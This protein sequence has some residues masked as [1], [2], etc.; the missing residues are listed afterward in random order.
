[1]MSISSPVL[2]TPVSILPVATVPRPVIE[3][4]SSTGIKKSFSTSRLGSSIQVSTSSINFITESTHFCSP[5]RA[6]RADP[7]TTGELSPS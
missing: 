4:T 1:M 3:K 2:A 5:L 6:P 7:K